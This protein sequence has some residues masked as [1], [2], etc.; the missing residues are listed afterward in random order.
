MRAADVRRDERRT[1]GFHHLKCPVV[2]SCRHTCPLAPTQRAPFG[3]S[4]RRAC[5]QY[6]FVMTTLSTSKKAWGERFLS[7]AATRPV[8]PCCPKCAYRP[9]LDPCFAG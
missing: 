5:P 4:G 2:G 3:T 6:G 9:C 8:V 7:R 1:L